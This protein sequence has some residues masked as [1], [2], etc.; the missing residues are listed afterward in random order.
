MISLLGFP[1]SDFKSLVNGHFLFYFSP[2]AATLSTTQRA[3][4]HFSF[5]V[6]SFAG[7]TFSGDQQD[8]LG[9]QYR[10]FNPED[11]NQT[12]QLNVVVKSREL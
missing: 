7:I 10:K 3:E 6:P 12:C 4:N 2:A 9:E 11:P 1:G 5:R 8:A